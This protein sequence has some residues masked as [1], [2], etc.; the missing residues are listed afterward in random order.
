[1]KSRMLNDAELASIRKLN[2]DEKC[3]LLVKKLGRRSWKYHSHSSIKRIFNAAGVA[4]PRLVDVDYCFGGIT[5]CRKNTR[6]KPTGLEDD[7]YFWAIDHYEGLIPTPDPEFIFFCSTLFGATDFFQRRDGDDG[8][9]ALR[10]TDQIISFDGTP[11]KVSRQVRVAESVNSFI[12]VQAILRDFMLHDQKFITGYYLEGA[13]A[14][15]LFTLLKRQ[16]TRFESLDS[17][18]VVADFDRLSV[19]V[20]PSL[21]LAKN[22]KVE[23]FK[24]SKYSYPAIERTIASMCEKTFIGSFDEELGWT[25]CTIRRDQ[26]S[27]VPD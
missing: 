24:T 18:C 10:E 8:I 2:L 27:D 7:F 15:Q 12:A 17:S 14:E 9:Y 13:K 20:R 26:R 1:M 22:L 11:I 23:V 5:L 19:L 16:T 3:Y 6:F 4:S 21:R 25:T